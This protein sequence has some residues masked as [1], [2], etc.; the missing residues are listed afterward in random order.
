MSYRT[1]GDFLSV[2]GGQGLSKGKQGLG[3]GDGW[4]PGT[5][6]LGSGEGVLGSGGWGLERAGRLG[7]VG[8]GWLWSEGGAGAWPQ[9]LGGRDGRSDGRSLVCL[10][11]H[12]DGRKFKRAS[13]QKGT[14]LKPST[15]S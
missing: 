9:A 12:S 4:R 2:R 11:A 14:T 10:L 5:R 8:V 6:G 15:N 13:R 1:E 7:P 3:G